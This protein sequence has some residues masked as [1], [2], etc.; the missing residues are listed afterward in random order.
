MP[1]LPIDYSKAVIYK[2]VCNDLT[3]KEAYYGSTTDFIKRK[4]NHKT[5]CNNAKSKEYNIPKYQFIRENGGWNNWKMILIKE[6]PCDNK[7]QLEAEERRIME[8]DDFRLNVY[9]PFITDEELKNESLERNKTHYNQNKD[10]YKEINKK[11]REKNPVRIKNY[12]KENRDK[13]KEQRQNRDKLKKVV[14]REQKKI[15]EQKNKD[16]INE[17]QRLR[18]QL[19]KLTFL[20]VS[21]LSS[22]S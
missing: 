3:I 14:I 19:N 12:N 15:W 16:K 8:K 11:Y 13:I 22:L 2:I 21:W 5:C 7:R 6:Y 17:Q 20:A 9:R 10:T 18:Y 4:W 1:R